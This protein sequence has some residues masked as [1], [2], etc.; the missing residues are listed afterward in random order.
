[1]TIWSIFSRADSY[2]S[3]LALEYKVTPANRGACIYLRAKLVKAVFWLRT[4]VLMS[5]FQAQ[6]HFIPLALTPLVPWVDLPTPQE[7]DS[8]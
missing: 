4:T 2:Q 8:P 7:L 1:M 3:L 5:S 6:L